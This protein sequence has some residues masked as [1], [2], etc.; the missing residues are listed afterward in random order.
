MVSPADAFARAVA[1][2]PL[3]LLLLLLL[4]AGPQAALARGGGGGGDV[5]GILECAQ[6]AERVGENNLLI[7]LAG[8]AAGTSATCCE[9]AR[10]LLQLGGPGE[11]A[12]CVCRHIVLE[13]TL[14]RVEQNPLAKNFGV[15]RASVLNI[16]QQCGVKYAG[17]EGENACPA[18]CHKNKHCSKHGDTHDDDDDQHHKHHDDHHKHDDGKHGRRLMRSSSS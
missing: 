16:L 3:L 17:G 2:A 13:Q 9:S 1:A 15:T 4:A 8:C 14:S 11:L 12:G 6:A 18:P 5:P 7:R 10:G